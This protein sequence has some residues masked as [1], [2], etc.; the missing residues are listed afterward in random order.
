MI[1]SLANRVPNADIRTAIPPLKESEAIYKSP[2]WLRLM[3]DII[4]ERGR[5]CED[6]NHNYNRTHKL[7]NE[8]PSPDSL[9]RI[10]GDHIVELSDGGAALD[11]SN[12]MLRCAVCHGRKTALVAINR[13]NTKY[14]QPSA[15]SPQRSTTTNYTLR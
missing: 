9:G 3:A 8:L 1:P 11:K 15:Q 10:Y 6:P 7:K 2:S 14:K 5:I 4:A 13:R 12:I